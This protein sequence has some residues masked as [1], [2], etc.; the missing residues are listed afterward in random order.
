MLDGVGHIGH[1]GSGEVGGILTILRPHIGGVHTSKPIIH[2]HAQKSL[3][4]TSYG[5][6]R[7]RKLFLCVKILLFTQINYLISVS[8]NIFPDPVPLD[9]S[10]AAQKPAGKVNAN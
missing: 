2:I 1:L 5:H 4:C 9:E 6:Q 3:F 8:D 7:S 10:G